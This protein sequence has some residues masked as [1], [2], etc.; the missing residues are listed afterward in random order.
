MQKYA[1]LDRD[2]TLIF[3]PQDNFRIDSLERLLILPNAISGL[4]KLQ[5]DGFKLILISNQ[6]GIGSDEFPLEAFQIPH[7]RFLTILAT[8]GIAFE[9]VFICPHLPEAHC[10]C[11][12]PKTGL[13]DDSE[14]RTQ[15]ILKVL[16]CAA[17]A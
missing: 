2:G 7:D 5:S 6:D 14:K 13:V 8:E 16:L 4:K 1:F 11:R 12:K 15:S 3:E 17:T 9:K 10:T